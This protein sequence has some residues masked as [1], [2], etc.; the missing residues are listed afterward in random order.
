MNSLNGWATPMD[1]QNLKNRKIM[2]KVTKPTK[3]QLSEN[4]EKM[5]AEQ[6]KMKAVIEN[7]K[8]KKVNNN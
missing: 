6:Q 1:L 3:K 2:I 4:A 5:K 7:I 8:S